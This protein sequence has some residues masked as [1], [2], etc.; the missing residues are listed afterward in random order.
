MAA[1]FMKIAKA[2]A[3]LSP[4]YRV[5]NGY[6]KIGLAILWLLRSQII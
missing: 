6:I 3:F 5:D 4:D 1:I 2:N